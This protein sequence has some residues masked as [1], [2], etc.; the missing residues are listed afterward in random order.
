MDAQLNRRAMLQ[1]CG[2]GAGALGLY[3]LLQ[4][5]R[6]LGAPVADPLTA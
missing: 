3:S 1:R 4:D 6:L 2:L 5:E